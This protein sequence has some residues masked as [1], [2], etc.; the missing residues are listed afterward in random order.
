MQPWQ[1]ILLEV[2]CCQRVGIADF[3]DICGWFLV[4]GYGIGYGAHKNEP[5]R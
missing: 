2:L 5:P 3:Y 1:G 4:V